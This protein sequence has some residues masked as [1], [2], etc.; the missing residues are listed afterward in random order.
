MHTPEP[1]SEDGARMLVVEPAL[2]TITVTVTVA[3]T[4]A[5]SACQWTDRGGPSFQEGRGAILGQSDDD[6]IEHLKSL[7]GGFMMAGD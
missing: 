2:A 5:A 3:V 4:P 1:A 7:F 6:G